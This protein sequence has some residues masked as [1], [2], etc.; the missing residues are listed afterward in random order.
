M[1]VVLQLYI[2]IIVFVN[3]SQVICYLEGPL[4]LWSGRFHYNGCGELVVDN[5][6]CIYMQCIIKSMADC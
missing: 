2:Y 6:V 4:S 3:S 5:T 1:Y